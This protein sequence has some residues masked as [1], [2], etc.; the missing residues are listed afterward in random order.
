MSSRLVHAPGRRPRA[1]GRLVVRRSARR[2]RSSATA[3]SAR[4]S[5][6]AP[7]GTARRSTAAGGSTAPGSLLLRRAV[8]DV[9]HGPGAHPRRATARRRMMLF[10]APRS[11]WEMLDDW[12]DLLGLKGSGS[13]SVQLR[14]TRSS[15]TTGR[16][17]D[18]QMVEVDVSG[19]TPGVALHGNPMYAGRR[20]LLLHRAAAR[21][22]SAPPTARSTSTSAIVHDEA[23]PAPADRRPRARTPTTSAGSAR[24]SA[25]SRRRR[26]RCSARADQQTE[27]CR[28][29]R[30][31]GGRR[32]LRARTT[33]SL[34]F[35]AREADA[36]GV[37]RDAGA[38]HPHRRLQRA[39]ATA[40]ACSGSSAT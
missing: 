32:D 14:R 1:A 28:A 9:L 19:G 10:V 40:S 18:T 12:G 22:W 5:V 29:A 8:L 34:D 37:G 17:A 35:I 7:V 16:C 30:R 6:A 23:H 20:V 38:H 11:Q 2:T 26:R 36:H 13:H 25:R 15:P 4:A 33:C 27:N 31:R 21:S 39:R 3:T 24:R